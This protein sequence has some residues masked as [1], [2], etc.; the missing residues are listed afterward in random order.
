MSVYK[1]YET[2][3]IE[4][5]DADNR[6]VSSEEGSIYF[7]T[8]MP[9]F[10]VHPIGSRGG[11][12]IGKVV[13]STN[14]EYIN[15]LTSFIRN[16]IVSITEDN[17]LIYVDNDGNEHVFDLNHFSDST[18][19]ITSTY[20]T[21]LDSHMSSTSLHLNSTD[22]TNLNNYSTTINNINTSISGKANSSHSQAASTITG[23]TF[24]GTMY[25]HS[26]YQT[27][28]TSLIRNSK[29]V[30]SETNPTVNGEI[31]WVYE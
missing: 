29:L 31:N 8:D 15:T 28:G 9:A 25:A 12:L 20:K 3:K 4:F 23:G 14:D 11:F 6:T 21:S 17:S 13:F 27:P 22:R 30:T 2:T 5:L 26:S 18:K 10:Y 7:I 1:Y 24:A 19:H 16:T